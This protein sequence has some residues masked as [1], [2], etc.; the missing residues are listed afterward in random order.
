LLSKDASAHLQHFL[1]LCDTIAIKDVTLESIR[2]H[3]FPFSL[4]GKAKQ[5]FNKDKEAVNMWDKCSMAFLMKFF[6]TGKTH[7]LRGE[8]SNFQQNSKPLCRESHDRVIDPPFITKKDPGHNHML[9][10]PACLPQCLL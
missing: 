10:W 5:W 7:A 1:E 9:N 6:L 2:L 8:F 4:T 3:L